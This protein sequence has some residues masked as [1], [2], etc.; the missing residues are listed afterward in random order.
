MEN[1]MEH[2]MVNFEGGLLMEA[3]FVDDKL[4]G[5][6]GRTAVIVSHEMNSVTVDGKWYEICG[7]MG[8]LYILNEVV[9]EAEPIKVILYELQGKAVVGVQTKEEVLKR[10]QY[11]EIVSV[12]QY[13]DKDWFIGWCKE[14]G[15]NVVCENWEGM[16]GTQVYIKDEDGDGYDVDGNKIDGNDSDV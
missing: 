14:Q 6:V 11:G 3:T 16:V 1:R 9:Q 4:V 10:V 5:C 15:T 12:V 7:C 8:T 13:I 2:L